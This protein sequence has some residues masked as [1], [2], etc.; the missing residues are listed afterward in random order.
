MQN[1]AGSY[2]IMKSMD[3]HVGPWNK[4]ERGWSQREKG[5]AGQEWVAVT[6]QT[7]KGR[8]LGAEK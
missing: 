3:P 1:V 2:R 4:K 5:E 8:W 7:R 6:L